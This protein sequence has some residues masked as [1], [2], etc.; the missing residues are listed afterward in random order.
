MQFSRLLRL[1]WS[2]QIFGASAES[3]FVNSNFTR[4][5]DPVMVNLGFGPLDLQ[6]PRASPLRMPKSFKVLRISWISWI[7]PLGGFSDKYYYKD[8][9]SIGL[10]R[11]PFA[12]QVVLENCLSSS[13]A[14]GNI[15]ENSLFQV[16]TQRVVAHIIILTTAFYLIWVIDQA[17]SQDG[18]IL[19]KFFFFCVFMDRDEVEVP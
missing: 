19:A 15:F 10:V 3:W 8:L 11:K 9:L 6:V 13:G 2:V 17:W 16:V 5:M 4:G 12:T 18:W 1:D 14:C 7:S